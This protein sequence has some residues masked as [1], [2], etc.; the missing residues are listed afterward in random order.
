MDVTA[1]P[2][3]ENP[4]RNELDK[5]ALF[6]VIEP[7]CLAHGVELVDVTFA[8]EAGGAVLRVLVDR[9]RPELAGVTAGPKAV[10][11]GV[12]LEDCRGISRDLGVVLDVHEN[13]LP[14][15][16]YRLEVGSPGLDRPLVRRRDFERFVEREI[17]V[18]TQSAVPEAAADRRRF[19]GRLVRVETTGDG[20]DDRIVV[21]DPTPAPGASPTWTISIASIVRANVVHRFD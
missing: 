4:M 8:R 13:L 2:M 14:S 1:T 18:Q 7:I 16:R 9:E 6:V 20:T 12:T 5:K 11:S 15:G 10:G 19:Q 21:E 17:K 3:R